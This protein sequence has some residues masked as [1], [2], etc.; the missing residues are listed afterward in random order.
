MRTVFPALAAALVAAGCATEVVG[1]GG[2]PDPAVAHKRQT[3][4]RE[5]SAEEAV[6]RYL[7][8]LALWE[9][10]PAYGLLSRIEQDK[11]ASLEKYEQGLERDR[12]TVVKMA[13]QAR[14]VSSGENPEE[15]YVV[16]VVD[17][18]EGRIEP[19]RTVLERGEWRVIL[20]DERRSRRAGP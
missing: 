20:P 17:L 5:R 14:V 15:P 3:T 11:F 6:L 1:R 19:F 12:A 13:Q 4:T 10:K 18:G 9:T 2:S 7:Q 16:V 8:H